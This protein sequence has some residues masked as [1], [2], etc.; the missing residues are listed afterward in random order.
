M[1]FIDQHR[2]AYGVEPIC[3]VLPIAP[4]TYYAHRAWRRDPE[5][6][7]TRK[8]RDAVLRD[9]IKR[10]WD[11]SEDGVYGAD[12]VWRQLHREGTRVARCTVERLMRSQGSS[13][14][15]RGK[16]FKDPGTATVRTNWLG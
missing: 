16:A 2:D 5:L 9:E 3:S 1:D 12:K 10:V 6:R 13:G 7:C 15:V 4:A 8:K 11:E 14:V